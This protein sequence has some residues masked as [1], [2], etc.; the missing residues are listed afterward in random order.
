MTRVPS[1]REEN[2]FLLTVDVDGWSSL[3]NYYSV[4]HNPEIA[5]SLVDVND[6]VET[7]LDLFKK[8]DVKSTF[9][10]TGNMAKDNKSMLKKIIR[11]GHEIACH[12]L[13]HNKN[14]FL[15]DDL[16]QEN[17][18]IKATQLITEISGNKPSGFRAPCL[19]L[20]ID[21]LKILNKLGYAYDSSV[22]PSYIPGYYGIIDAPKKPYNPS[23]DSISK[24]GDMNIVEIPVSVNPLIP[25]PLSAAWMRNL[26]T[27]WVKSGIKL[28]FYYDNPVAFYIHPRDVSDLP[29]MK[30]VPWHLYRNIGKKCVKMLDEII[31]FVK[32][33]KAEILPCIEYLKYV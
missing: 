2:H 3:L 22:I 31:K 29:R 23:S 18:I 19:R 14:E 7:L 8:N 17:S 25:L 28:N 20:N 24:R 9:F 4:D 11:N 21:T 32:E 30:G 27:Y 12:G 10:I 26:G 1:M 16:T 6:G 33:K 15:Q 5:A 13:T